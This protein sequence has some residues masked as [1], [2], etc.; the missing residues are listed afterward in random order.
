MAGNHKAAIT[1]Y[2]SAASRTT[3]LPE[4]NYLFT[5]AARLAESTVARLAAAVSE[6]KAHREKL[7]RELEIAREVQQRLFPQEL[8]RVPGIDCYGACR[9]ALMV[10]GDYYDFVLRADA[11]RFGV[12]IGDVAGKGISAAL[13]MASL[14]ASLRAEALRGGDDAGE[15][16]SK[17]NSLLCDATTANRYA[18]LFYGQFDATASTLTYVNAGHNAPVVLKQSNGS[19]EIVRLETGG[20]V[21]GLASQFTYQQARIKLDR[22]DLLVAFTDGITE[23]MNTAEEEWGEESLIRT[24]R[25]CRELTARQTVARIMEAADAFAAGAEQ[26]D[27]MTII[28]LRLM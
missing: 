21:I 24:I 23:A 27:D 11:E 20:T 1:H 3:S 4:R 19:G 16:V 15:I 12:A 22:G 2:Q 25:S 13:T 17:V 10:G 28:A 6:E 14:Q 7:S 18:T 26:H 9:P 8:P 5:Q